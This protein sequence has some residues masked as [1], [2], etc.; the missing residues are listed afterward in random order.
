MEDVSTL[1]LYVNIKQ[2]KYAA[3]KRMLTILAILTTMVMSSCSK[4]DDSEIR[5]KLNALEDRIAAIETL[6]KASADKLTVIDI[7][8]TDEGTVITFSDNSKVTIGKATDTKSPIVNIEVDGDM[9]YIT[10][11][12]GTVLIFR[13]Y[14]FN[15]NNKIYYTTTDSKVILWG[16]GV[17]SNTYENGQ[18]V[19]IFDDPV[20]SISSRS[21]KTLKSIVI[22]ETVVT[23]GS[24]FDCTSLKELYCKAI[25]PPTVTNHSFPNYFLHKQGL[26]Y[27]THPI[28]CAIYVPTESVDAY[29]KATCWSEYAKYIKGYDFE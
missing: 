26:N 7:T 23:I 11:D 14:E 16:D 19:A 4:Y 1:F 29:K 25:I 2:L 9:V 21:S 17:I 20:T 13:K 28:G 27:S 15:E 18:G 5:Q 3:M 22:P 24:F 8:E 6:L 10:L 12:D